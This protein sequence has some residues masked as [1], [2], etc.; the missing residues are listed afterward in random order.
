MTLDKKNTKN[1]I[2][3]NDFE[4]YQDDEIDLRELVKVIWN[5]KWLTVAMCAVA[6]AGSV[7]YALNAQE[8][9]VAKGKVVKPQ[10]ND[11]GV[12]YSQSKNVGA[13]INASNATA[14]KSDVRELMGLFEPNTL[15]NTFI[16]SFNSSLN[17]KLFLE[18]NS[19]FQQYLTNQGIKI[20]SAELTAENELIRESFRKELNNWMSQIKASHDPK[21]G[22][23]SL[24][25]RTDRKDSSAL[26]LNQYIDF[27]SEKVKLNQSE[28]FVLFVNSAKQELS[29][30]LEITKKRVEQELAVMLKKTEYAYQIASQADLSEYQTSRN[31]DAELFEI[32]LGEKALKA[33]VTVLKSLTDFSILDPSILQKQITLDALNNLKLIDNQSFVPFRYLEVVEPPFSR[34]EPKR[35]LIVIL[36]TLLAGMLS[37]FIALVHYFLTKKEN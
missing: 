27:V 2:N 10:L 7:F 37:I 25:F 11:V 33:K 20:P 23:V 14:D 4:A 9:W 18:N 28:K 8:W 3:V 22:E 30:S 34:A 16:I 35:A 19:F 13:I 29:V 36:A 5:Y 12:L 26:L 24:S 17:K 1:Q 6:I 31:P 32:N 21:N 15:F